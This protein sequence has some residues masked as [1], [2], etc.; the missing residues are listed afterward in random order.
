MQLTGCLGICAS[1]GVMFLV[2]LNSLT[3][4]TGRRDLSYEQFAQSVLGNKSL[5]LV[6]KIPTGSICAS[7]RRD[8]TLVTATKF[9]RKNGQFTRW[10]L[11]PRLVEGKNRRASPL[12]CPLACAEYN[13]EDIINHRSCAHN[14]S[15]EIKA[16]KKPSDLNAIRTHDLCD[17]D[18]YSY[19][20]VFSAVLPHVPVRT[21]W[22]ATVL[23]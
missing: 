4:G 21:V 7:S 14:F 19:L 8:Q 20:P 6:P 1:F 5:G 23:H 11:S 15:S 10:N 12:A 18:A 16:W 17:T 3:E 13:L 9:W 22:H 2:P